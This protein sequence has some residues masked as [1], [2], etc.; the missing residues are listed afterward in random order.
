MSKLNNQSVDWHPA[1]ILVVDDTDSVRRLV[2]LFLRAEGFEVVEAANG[3]EARCRFEALPADL[4]VTDLYMPEEDGL[5][6]IAGLR[7][8]IPKIPV[9][10]V[11][12]GGSRGDTTTLQAAG[13]LGADAILEKPFDMTDLVEVI[14]GL[15]AKS[16][17]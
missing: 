12:G 1:R 8:Y 11:S 7:D 3:R 13:S 2:A 10:A 4:V 17:H 15:L 5:E 9:V 6:L 16:G 14:R